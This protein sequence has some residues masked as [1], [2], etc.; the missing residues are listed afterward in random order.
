M[1]NEEELEGRYLGEI[2]TTLLLCQT[3]IH[4]SPSPLTNTCFV[5]GVLIFVKFKTY[6]R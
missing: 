5:Q 1:E 6:K 4:Q 3:L 2:M